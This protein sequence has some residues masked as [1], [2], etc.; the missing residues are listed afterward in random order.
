MDYTSLAQNNKQ[1]R[2]L[3]S[4]FEKGRL[5]QVCLLV[6]SDSLLTESI[7]YGVAAAITK[8][9]V[10]TIAKKN[11]P[12]VF[13][14]GDNGKIDVANVTEII[15]TLAVR[16]Y[17]ANNKIYIL[18]G[19]ENMNESSQN[20]L[21]KSLE[22]APRDVIFLLSA[23][24]TKNILPTVLS[25]AAEYKIDNL[26]DE[27]IYNLLVGSGIKASS[28]EIAVSCAGGNSTL[29][30]KLTT[31]GFG[32][33]YNDVLKM[34]EKVNG[35]K[36]CLA[37]AHKFESKNVDKQE[38]LDICMLLVRDIAMILSGTSELVINKH[39]ADEL[40]IISEKCSLSACTKIMETCT[41]LKQDLVFNASASMV[42]DKLVLLIAEEKTKCRK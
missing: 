20:K 36:D 41:T 26:T 42:V 24:S 10:K 13:I 7:C 40:K 29:A 19:A 11:H 22:E 37:F 5:S 1:Y 27:Q 23:T 2:T 35:S 12:D 18:L 39:H 32:E 21:L 28:A 38:L 31:E 34:L 6:S 30:R 8:A 17:S 14:Y 9:D 3:L 25:R 16:P 33:L 4:L 15:E